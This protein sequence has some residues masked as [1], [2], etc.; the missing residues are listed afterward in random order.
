MKQ[1]KGKQIVMGICTIA[2]GIWLGYAGLDSMRTG[3]PV[4]FWRRGSTPLDG[5]MVIPIGGLLVFLGICVIGVAFGYVKLK[6]QE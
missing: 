1:S 6:G 2:A 3:I 4:P 5:W